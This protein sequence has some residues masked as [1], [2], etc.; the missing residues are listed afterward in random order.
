[1]YKLFND[2]TVW[3]CFI[4]VGFITTANVHAS[5]A[6]ECS[7]FQCCIICNHGKACWN[8]PTGQECEGCEC[9]FWGRPSGCGD[10]QPE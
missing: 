4:A 3:L 9:D 10:C 1:M 7:G 6:T 8:C 2:V 5:C